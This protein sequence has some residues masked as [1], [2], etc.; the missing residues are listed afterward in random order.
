MLHIINQSPFNSHALADCLRFAAATDVILLIEDGVYAALADSPA[1]QF[2]QPQFAQRS[3]YALQEDIL[4][5][6]ISNKTLVTIKTI[7]YAGF[8]D[9]TLAHFP[10]QT[11]S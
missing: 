8:V 2:L 7:D 3:V 11:W 10:T 4:K 6:N 9:L 1:L 5:R